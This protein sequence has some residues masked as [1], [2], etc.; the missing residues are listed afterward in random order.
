MTTQLTFLVQA[1][2]EDQ[3]VLDYRTLKEDLEG[4]LVKIKSGAYENAFYGVIVKVTVEGD[5]VRPLEPSKEQHA[6]DA[7]N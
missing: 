6:N 3:D 4:E 7:A 1:T 2:I 5:I